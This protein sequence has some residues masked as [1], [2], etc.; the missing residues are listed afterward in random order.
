MFGEVLVFG[1][2]AVAVTYGFK[3]RE[4]AWRTPSAKNC[5]RVTEL[6]SSEGSKYHWAQTQ[7]L[8][9]KAALHGTRRWSY[10]SVSKENMVVRVQTALAL[11]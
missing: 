3:G 1:S 8:L 7:E 10:E 11:P 4:K 2:T 6:G 9:A 5:L